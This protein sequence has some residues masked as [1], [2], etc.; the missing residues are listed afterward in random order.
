MRAKVRLPRDPLSPLVDGRF[1]WIVSLSE[2]SLTRIDSKSNKATT[3]R[4]GALPLA[5][6]AGAGSVWVGHE[7]ER[8]VWRFDPETAQPTAKI[9]IDDTV[10]GPRLWR[11]LCV[12]DG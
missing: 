1:V 8:A 2:N 6:A 3:I 10:R 7:V 12:G 4:V 5:L 9:T 11:R